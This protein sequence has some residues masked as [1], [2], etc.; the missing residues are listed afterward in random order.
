M[1]K[2]IQK[3]YS[4]SGNVFIKWR[5]QKEDI[6]FSVLVES[7]EFSC[8]NLT[9]EEEKTVLEYLAAYT[10]NVKIITGG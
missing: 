8:L 10:N 6:P 9:K 5:Y 2:E 1:E 3:E 4:I 7:I